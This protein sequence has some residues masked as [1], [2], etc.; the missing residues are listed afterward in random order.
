MRQFA[1]F[2]AAL[3]A[4]YQELK[5]QGHDVPVSRWQGVDTEGHFRETLFFDF[6]V[7]VERPGRTFHESFNLLQLLAQ[8]IQPNLPWADDHFL[9]RVSGVPANPGEQYKNWPYWRTESQ[10]IALEDKG[11]L[12]RDADLAYF[13]GFLDADGTVDL[14]KTKP[15]IHVYQKDPKILYE[16]QEMLGFGRVQE[17]DSRHGIHVLCITNKQEVKWLLPKIIPHLRVKRELAEEALSTSLSLRSH[18]NDKAMASEPRFSHTYMQRFWPKSLA[19]GIE[20]PLGDLDDVVQLLFEDP[21]TRQAYLPIWFPEDTGAV[22]KERV[23]CTIGYFF[24][25]RNNRLHMRYHIRS[26]DF[27]RYLR[28][29]IYMAVRLQLWILEQLVD[30]ELRSDISQL[31][32]DVTP[33]DFLMDIDSLHVIGGDFGVRPGRT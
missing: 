23:P 1:T 15:R 29:D 13:A 14:S 31:W 8:E 27:N 17:H 19:H 9:E 28:D 11:P 6:R 12:V 5:T 21:Y 22:H 18:G 2:D 7:R 33:G 3:R 16:F 30:K 20:F 4:A 26:C 25:M 10:D 24:I 32:V